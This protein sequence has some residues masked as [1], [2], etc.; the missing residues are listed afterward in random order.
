MRFPKKDPVCSASVGSEGLKHPSKTCGWLSFGA[1]THPKKYQVCRSPAED[2]SLVSFCHAITYLL[3]LASCKTKT[4]P[5]PSTPWEEMAAEG[6]NHEEWG[7]V[8][9]LAEVQ[10]GFLRKGR[11]TQVGW[12]QRLGEQVLPTAPHQQSHR[13]GEMLSAALPRAAAPQGPCWCGKER[14][15]AGRVKAVPCQRNA[16]SPHLHIFKGK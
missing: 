10:K 15:T 6:T 13:P 4:Y 9:W 12:A 1:Q 2:N 14:G 3:L 16:A 7:R 8:Q 11:T 5:K